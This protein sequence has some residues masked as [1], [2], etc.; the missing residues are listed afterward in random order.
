MAATTIHLRP[1]PSDKKDSMVRRHWND[2]PVLVRTAIERE[3]GPVMRVDIPSTGRHS[4]FSAVLHLADS[5]VFCKGIRDPASKRG[6]MHHHEA[7]INR[8]LPITVT[9][10]LQWR[11]EVSNWLLL[12]FEHV[13]GRHADLSPGSADL[14]M[15]ADLLNTLTHDLAHCPAEAP[16]LA[17]QWARLA[18]W[19][20]LAMNLPT[21]LDDWAKSHLGLLIDWETRAI[22][23]VDGDALAHTDLHSLNII[24]TT[25]GGAKAVDWAWSRKADAAVD[26]AFLIAR[27][28]DA[29]NTIATAEEWAETIPKWRRTDTITRTALAV[30]IWGIWEYLKENKPLPHRAD[31]TDSIKSWAR[32]RLISD[33]L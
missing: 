22:D 2:L 21:A 4:D 15:T 3:T 29:G 24:V 16:R 19:R 12:G 33:T 10:R 7:E 17:E 27:L 14:A 6:R 13:A 28:I 25:D 26:I 9:P 1:P 5:K 11:S 8:W 31:L 18:A 23:L 20:R 32:H 30:A